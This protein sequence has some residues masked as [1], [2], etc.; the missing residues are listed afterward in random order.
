MGGRVLYLREDEVDEDG[1]GEEQGAHDGEGQGE[2]A[3]LATGEVTGDEKVGSR[4][5]HLVTGEGKGGR[6]RRLT[7]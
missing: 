2:A 6:R 3:H 4:E 1:G 5:G 7:W